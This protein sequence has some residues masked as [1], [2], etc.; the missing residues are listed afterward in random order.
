[1]TLLSRR[2]HSPLQPPD[3]QTPSIEILKSPLRCGVDADVALRRISGVMCCRYRVNYWHA[4]TPE[5]W[6]SGLW[7][8][9]RDASLTSRLSLG[10]KPVSVSMSQFKFSCVTVRLC[11]FTQEWFIWRKSVYLSFVRVGPSWFPSVLEQVLSLY[12]NF[13]LN[14]L[15]LIQPAQN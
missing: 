1:M 3:F 7:G 6:V 13:T 14:C 4:K 11:F 12:Q 5:F 2:M 15:L 10:M 9:S 8:F